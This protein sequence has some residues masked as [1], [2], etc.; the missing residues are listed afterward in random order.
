MVHYGRGGMCQE[1]EEA[2]HVPVVRKPRDDK[3]WGLVLKPQGQPPVPDFL[4]LGPTSCRHCNL[5]G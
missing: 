4:Q 1:C 5:P 2:D 3:T